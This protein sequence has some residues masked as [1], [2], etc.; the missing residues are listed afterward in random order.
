MDQPSTPES[1]DTQSTP[2]AQPVLAFVDADIASG[3]DEVAREQMLNN[4]RRYR[5]N[6]VAPL[7]VNWLR[8]RADLRFAC[9]VRDVGRVQRLYARRRAQR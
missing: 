1:H 7:W 2:Y 8:Q 3:K 6:G 5:A 4:L 9:L